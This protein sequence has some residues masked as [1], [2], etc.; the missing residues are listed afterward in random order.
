MNPIQKQ[1]ETVHCF[2]FYCSF[3]SKNK[4]NE[5]TTMV[6]LCF[7]A[8]QNSRSSKSKTKQTTFKKPNIRSLGNLLSELSH[9]R[10]SG[11]W[12]PA[13]SW[14][15]LV[16]SGCLVGVKSNQESNN[17]T[18]LGAF[19][20]FDRAG[21]PLFAGSTV[22]IKAVLLSL[23]SPSR[24]AQTHTHTNMLLYA[25][26]LC[27]FIFWT[28]SCSNIHLFKKTKHFLNFHD[29]CKGL[30]QDVMKGTIL[31]LELVKAS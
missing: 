28:E 5:K 24:T 25:V 6:S 2:K 11:C 15:K 17:S 8:C 1:L 31:P 14:W 3:L 13:R 12:G 7:H 22:W 27:S 23:V 20:S 4:N 18:L 30:H 19:D 26:Y 21:W 9:S 29:K 10:P 16:T